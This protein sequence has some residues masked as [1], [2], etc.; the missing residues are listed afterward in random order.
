MGVC[1]KALR[2]VAENEEALSEDTEREL[3]FQLRQEE[4]IRILLQDSDLTGATEPL[5]P[6]SILPSDQ[7]QAALAYGGIY[8][9]RLVTPAR[10][11]TICSLL[12]SPLY[13]PFFRLLA[14]P[15]AS[16]YHDYATT[17]A[18]RTGSVQ[19]R[20][21]SI[22]SAAFLKSVKL[23]AESP[24]SVVT[25]VGSGGAIAMIQKVRA[26]MKEKRTEWSAVAELPVSLSLTLSVVPREQC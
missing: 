15:Y 14:S 2:W 25:Q 5:L 8:F 13:M 16:I 6:Q 12:T 26:V 1:K 20:L 21:Q 18:G 4:F 9:R 24:L 3:E 23:P 19:L 22:F 11:A 7:A 10:Q 17:T